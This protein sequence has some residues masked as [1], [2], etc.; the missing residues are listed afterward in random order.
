MPSG[1][2]F[3]LL[4]KENKGVSDADGQ[5]Q[6]QGL[7]DISSSTYKIKMNGGLGVSDD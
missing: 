5:N 6:I 1:L 3:H 4:F 7:L 2:G